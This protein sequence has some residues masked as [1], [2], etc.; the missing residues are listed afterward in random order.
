MREICETEALEGL[1]RCAAYLWVVY[2]TLKLKRLR[3][4]VVRAIGVL[5]LRWVYRPRRHHPSALKMRKMYRWAAVEPVK[6]LATRLYEFGEGG[7]VAVFD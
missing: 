1:G 7:M 5:R 2:E 6:L 4:H 3:L